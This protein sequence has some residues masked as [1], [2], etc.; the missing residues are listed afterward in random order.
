MIDAHGID[1]AIVRATNQMS[2]VFINCEGL[3]GQANLEW[4]TSCAN[5]T[6]PYENSFL[7]EATL[8]LMPANCIHSCAEGSTETDSKFCLAEEAGCRTLDKSIHLKMTLSESKRTESSD[9]GSGICSMTVDELML[10]DSA[11]SQSPLLDNSTI[12]KVSMTCECPMRCPATLIHPKNSCSTNQTAPE[13]DYAKHNRGF[14]L[15]L[16]IRILATA[17]LG[18]SW[19]MLDAST[20]C[21][22]KKHKGDL[23]KQRL[24]GVIGS[25]VF[26]LL[27]GI[28]LD[29]ASSLNNGNVL[30]NM[31]IMFNM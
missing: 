13:Y 28:V 1:P 12:T 27:S 17:S 6:C 11:Q 24:F 14:W 4:S 10:F 16:I 2:S 22:I 9:T 29:W 8:R 19:V 23:G 20:L 7:T 30:R 15:Y 25:A 26:G 5:D 3:S 18:T 31:D 21:L